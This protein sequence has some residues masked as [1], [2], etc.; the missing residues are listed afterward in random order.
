MDVDFESPERELLS[1]IPKLRVLKGIVYTLAFDDA[2]SEETVQAKVRAF[3]K[4]TSMERVDFN[5]RFLG[6]SDLAEI[7]RSCAR[8][9]S[10]LR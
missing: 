2:D 8:N 3:K 6:D 4:N 9:E 5:S 7:Q 1:I 10:I